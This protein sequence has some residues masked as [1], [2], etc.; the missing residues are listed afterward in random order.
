MEAASIAYEVFHDHMTPAPRDEPK[1]PSPRGPGPRRGDGPAARR[2]DL[3]DWIVAALRRV[4]PREDADAALALLDDAGR[5]LAEGHFEVALRTARRAK[6]KAPRDATVREVIGIAAYRL[7]SWQEAL[8][9]LRTYRRLA[10]DD[11]HLPVEMDILRA[12]GRPDGVEQTWAQVLERVDDEEVAAE[13]AVVYAAFLLDEDR[14]EEAADVAAPPRPSAHP[15]PW[16]LKRWHVAARAAAA[17]GNMPAA[18]RWRDAIAAADPGAPGLDEL[19]RLIG[20][21]RRE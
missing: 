14:P 2:L 11:V 13:A 7:Q 20:G 5:A 19:D 17:L 3:Q 9:E 8:R 12:L 4:T 15:P 1:R 6:A 16:H 18:H 10:G 21:P